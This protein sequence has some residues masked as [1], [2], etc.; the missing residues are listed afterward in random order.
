MEHILEE[1]KEYYRERASQYSDWTHRTSEWEQVE[2]EPED[3]WFEDAQ[4]V[5]K[6]L[7]SDR[8]TGDVL[9]IASGTGEWTEV[10]AK[11]AASVTSS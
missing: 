3:S 1:T 4:I 10:L 8:L 5:I 2:I 9:E 6:A 11:S 7:E